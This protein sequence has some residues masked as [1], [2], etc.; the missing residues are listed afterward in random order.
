M[1]TRKL[2]LLAML[3][4]IV[5]VLQFLGA[6][7]HFGVFSISLVLLPV[8]GGAALVGPLAG[9]WLGFVFGVVVLWSGDAAPF[10]AVSVLPTIAIVIVKGTAAGLAAGFVYKLLE[11]KN[12][13]AAVFTAAA[14]APIVNTGIFLLGG[15][16]FFLPTLREWG[17]AAGFADIGAFLFLGLVGGNFIFEFIFNVVL[18]PVIVRLIQY[19][20]SK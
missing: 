20:Q 8:V 9:A 13:L 18:S 12:K 3:T 6:F 5:V 19:G 17:T 10:L 4:A 7:I 14:V 15:V 11:G 2:V 1:N 16:A